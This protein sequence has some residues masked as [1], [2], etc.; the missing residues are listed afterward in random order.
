[1]ASP[2]SRERREMAGFLAGVPRSTRH[3]AGMATG[4]ENDRKPLIFL[5]GAI[6]S[7]P[8][9][10]AG[11]EEAG[12]RLREIQEGESLGMPTSRPMPSIGPRVHELRIRDAEHDWRIIDRIDPAVIL[13]VA[14]FAKAT[15]ATPKRV[16]DQCRRRLNN[17]DAR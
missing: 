8:F 15:R 7:P 5:E 17:Y 6:K 16:I 10:A 13:I 2:E 12:T 1:M 9:T 3:H 14:V 11:R 4:S